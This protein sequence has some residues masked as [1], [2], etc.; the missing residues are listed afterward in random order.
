V[1][2]SRAD[3]VLSPDF[4]DGVDLVA[5][6]KNALR[7]GGFS[8]IDVRANS[9]VPH[10]ANVDAHFFLL[11]RVRSTEIRSGTGKE[12]PSKNRAVFEQA[13]GFQAKAP[14]TAFLEP[15]FQN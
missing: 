1:V 7:Q 15:F 2:Q 3:S 6:K 5:I 14:Q 4:V 8:R 9:N 11:L 12:V 13:V 10:P